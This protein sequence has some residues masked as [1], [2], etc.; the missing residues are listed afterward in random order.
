MNRTDLPRNDDGRLTAYA[1]PG[2]YPVFYI[3]KDGGALCP[4]CAREAEAEGLT[5]D[6]DDAQW[7][8]VAGDVNWEDD[9]LYCDHCNKIIESAYGES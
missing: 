9:A 6:P 4:D 1:W 7:C 5:S 3:T 2:G 8:I